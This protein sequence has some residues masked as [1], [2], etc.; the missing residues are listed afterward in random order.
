MTQ[1]RPEQRDDL[2][3]IRTVHLAAFETTA[4]ADLVDA[5]RASDAWLPDLSIVAVVERQVVA[6]ALFSRLVLVT[7]AGEVPALALGPVAVLPEMQR[8]GYGSATIRAALARRD[9]QLV[10]VLGDPAYYGRFGFRPGAGFGITGAYMSFRE[11]W[12]VLPPAAGTEPGE[13]LYPAPWSEV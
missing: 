12:Q 5:L 4:E 7:A 11:A 3:G 2:A 9:D 6:H 10:V 8:Q 1:V 13:V